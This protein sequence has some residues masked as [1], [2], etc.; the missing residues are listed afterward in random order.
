M[1]PGQAHPEQYHLKKE[2][3]FHILHGEIR[4]ALDGQEETYNPGEVIMV[5]RGVRHMFYSPGGAVFE[6]ISSTHHKDDSY[7]TDA[8]IQNN[9]NRK[10]LL[11]HWML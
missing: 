11:T 10:T 3:T 4:I 7:Y 2:E 5:D 8:T 1:L 6:E 9:K